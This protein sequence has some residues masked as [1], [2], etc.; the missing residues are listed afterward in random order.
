MYYNYLMPQD[1]AGLDS[2]VLEVV[3][4]IKRKLILKCNINVNTSL[5]HLKKILATPLTIVLQAH[6]EK[7][8]FL[9]VKLCYLLLFNWMVYDYSSND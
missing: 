5:P 2:L 1:F 7:K 4:N 6:P 9:A 8:I 3:R